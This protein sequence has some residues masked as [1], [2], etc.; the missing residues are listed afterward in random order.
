MIPRPDAPAAIP[1][2][3]M[4]AASGD[5]EML[6]NSG[7][8]SAIDETGTG[9]LSNRGDRR[10]MINVRACLWLVLA[11][12]A[13][14]FGFAQEETEP[15]SLEAIRELE[16]EGDESQTVS[17]P[18]ELGTVKVTATRRETDLYKTSIAVTA[19]SQETLTRDGVKDIRDV[20]S[21]VPNL[22][23]AFSPSDSTYAW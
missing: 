18:A 13:P 12:V 15:D 14:S 17:S 16:G 7:Y 5:R 3:G 9:T 19:I 21:L 20:G 10:A 1:D 2:S 22:D 8:S 6:G 23:V 11:L 4:P